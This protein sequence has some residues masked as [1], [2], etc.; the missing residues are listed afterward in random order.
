MTEIAAAGPP[1]LP[2]PGRRRA[3]GGGGGSSA[4]RPHPLPLCFAAHGIKN[5]GETDPE[6][7]R[8][9]RHPGH[10]GEHRCACGHRW[11][12]QPHPGGCETRETSR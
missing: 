12:P 9:C 4:S 5:C 10:P 8:C 11:D 1:C 6:W 7:C 2:I 3:R